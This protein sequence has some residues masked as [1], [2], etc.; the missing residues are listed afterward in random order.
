MMRGFHPAVLTAVYW[1]FVRAHSRAVDGTRLQGDDMLGAGHEWHVLFGF[2][3][4]AAGVFR[5]RAVSTCVWQHD[6]ARLGPHGDKY[7]CV[8][9]SGAT[10]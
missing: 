5:M 10:P 8:L 2:V 3:D 6:H 7:V 1:E 9:Q 4:Q